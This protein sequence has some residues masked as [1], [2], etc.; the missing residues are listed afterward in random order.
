MKFFLNKGDEHVGEH[1]A[2]D[3][4]LDRVIAVSKKLLDAQVLLNPFEEQL[5]LPAAFV[6]SS[7]GQGR[8]RSVVGEEDQSLL[9]CWVLEPDTA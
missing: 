6:Q 4:R 5:D 8:Q 9:G 7:H 3:L 2:P 1:G